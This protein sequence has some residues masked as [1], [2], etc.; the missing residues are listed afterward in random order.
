MKTLKKL[1]KCEMSRVRGGLSFVLGES[2]VLGYLR[3][4]CNR[5]SPRSRGGRFAKAM[6]CGPKGSENAH[7]L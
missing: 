6:L 3:R 2:T 7:M 5:W 1:E 4:R